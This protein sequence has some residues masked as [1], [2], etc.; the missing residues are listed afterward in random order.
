MENNFSVREASLGASID[1]VVAPRHIEFRAYSP[2]LPFNET[3]RKDSS[4]RIPDA[5]GPSCTRASC[6]H[7]IAPFGSNLIKRRPVKG[8]EAGVAVGL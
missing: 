1:R 6:I 3:R 4:P 7:R 5:S 8:S 2:G